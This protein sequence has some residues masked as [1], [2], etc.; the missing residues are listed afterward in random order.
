MTTTP[1]VYTKKHRSGSTTT[2][3]KLEPGERALIVRDDRHYRLG[4]Q[5]N[6]VVAGHVLT[7]TT[8]VSWCSVGQEWAEVGNPVHATKP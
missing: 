6:D 3:L 1:R 5:V 8:E 2:W 4:G 7:E